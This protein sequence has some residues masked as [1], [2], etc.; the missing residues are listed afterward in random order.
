MELMPLYLSIKLATISTAVLIISTMPI[1]YVLARSDWKGK[2]FVESL[3]SL[4]LVLPP[5]MFG[6]FL[7]YILSPISYI[8][9]MWG[10]AFGSPLLFSFT[11]IVLGSVI[12]SVPFAI[13][14]MKSVF[15]KL[16]KR[17]YE[18]AS[19]L[20]LSPI[21]VFFRV[22]I[23]N[24]VSGIMASAILVFLHSIGAFGVILMI[25]GSIPNETRVVSVAIFEAVL[26]MDYEKAWMLSAM[27]LPI[28]YVF[29]LV[30]NKLMKEK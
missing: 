15:A 30:V 8:G 25:G 9:K 7:L 16:D 29:L 3:L 14:P 19:I 24:S 18:S 13:Q 26:S 11:G 2:M 22:A 20:G 17:L 21:A 1:A 23:P 12:Y 6:F 4:P 10:N 27:L 5:T 28:S